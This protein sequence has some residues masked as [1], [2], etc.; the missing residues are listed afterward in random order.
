M[1]RLLLATLLLTLSTLPAIAADDAHRF[2]DPAAGLGV[3]RPATWQFVDLAKPV[4]DAG[5]DGAAAP[6]KPPLGPVVEMRKLDGVTTALKPNFKATLK[7]FG[8]IPREDAKWFFETTVA[9]VQ[10]HMP[11]A[12]LTTPVHAVKVGGRDGLHAAI[13]A[14]APSS[15]GVVETGTVELWMVPLGDV[16]YLLGGSY[17]RDD[18]A[19]QAEFR[20]II[21]S[22]ELAP[23]DT[24]D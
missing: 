11:G 2:T 7:A 8:E 6:A 14:A 21:A 3:T 24:A 15:E 16:Y 1:T 19:A 22:L 20:S 18:R 5:A 12:T 23:V 13:E 17:P 4:V 9:S 10:A